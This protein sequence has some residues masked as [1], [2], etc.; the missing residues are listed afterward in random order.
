MAEAALED[1]E[2]LREERERAL[3]K[4]DNHCPFGCTMADLDEYGYCDHLIGFANKST[5]GST[6]E[7]VVRNP[8]TEAMQVNGRHKRK[9]YTTWNK[10]RVPVLPPSNEVVE[11]GDKIVNPEKVQFVNGIQNVA[12]LWVSSRVYRQKKAP[13]AKAS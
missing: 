13:V 2:D 6:V 4:V 1:L 12:K 11:K 10:E 8:L 3:G 5:I 7:P 9:P